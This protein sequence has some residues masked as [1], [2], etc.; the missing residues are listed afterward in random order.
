MNSYKTMKAVLCNA[1][2]TYI[3]FAF[4]PHGDIFNLSGTVYWL[5]RIQNARRM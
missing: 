4:C 3:F 5:L 1:S 2:S